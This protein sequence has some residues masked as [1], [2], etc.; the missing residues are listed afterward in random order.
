[1]FVGFANGYIEAAHYD[2]INSFKRG[3]IITHL[4]KNMLKN[5]STT[6]II[7]L[8]SLFLLMRKTECVRLMFWA[9]VSCEW[10]IVNI[11]ISKRVRETT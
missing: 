2:I 11:E 8:V 7:G 4:S 9:Y 1:M 6:S 3:K 5:E 10:Y